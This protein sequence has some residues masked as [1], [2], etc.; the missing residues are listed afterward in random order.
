MFTGIVNGFAPVLR[1]REGGE[2]AL[3]FSNIFQDSEPGDSVSVDGVCLTVEKINNQEVVFNLSQDT[4]ESTGWT[5]KSLYQ[6]NVNIELSL[7]LNSRIGG[8][9]ITGHV[10]G[11]AQVEEICRKTG[12][13]KIKIPE[14]FQ[15][16]LVK[17][18]Y[19][20]VNGVS[21]TIQELE[22]SLIRLGIVPETFKRTNLGDLKKGAYVNFEI[23]YLTRILTSQ[24]NFEKLKTLH[25]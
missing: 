17:K 1:I 5:L 12:L 25:T 6:K 23:C 21:L 18:G 7:K 10:D 13:L 2:L 11:S 16:F 9:L 15:I 8:H 24:G 20:A 4:L 19:I 14:K 3:Q 22:N